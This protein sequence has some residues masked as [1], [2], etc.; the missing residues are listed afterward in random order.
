MTELKFKLNKLCN[1][2]EKLYPA[3]N[4]GHTFGRIFASEIWGLIFGILRYPVFV[5]L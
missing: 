5:H 3:Y 1:K 4:R 2:A